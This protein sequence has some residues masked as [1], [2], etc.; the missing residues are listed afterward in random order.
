MT[1]VRLTLATVVALSLFAAPQFGELEF[2][3]SG[4]SGR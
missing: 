1:H 2:H 3:R 4:P